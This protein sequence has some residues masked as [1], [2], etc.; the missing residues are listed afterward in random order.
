MSV[1]DRMTCAA[2]VPLTGPSVAS[3]AGAMAPERIGTVVVEH[4]ALRRRCPMM[5]GSTMPA[6]L[7]S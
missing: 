3:E 6:V 1:R 7:G 2:P 5:P 4:E